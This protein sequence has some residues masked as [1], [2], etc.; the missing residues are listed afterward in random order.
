MKTVATRCSRASTLSMRILSILALGLLG[1]EMAGASSPAMCD[2]TY[3][4]GF[5]TPDESGLIVRA[6][7]ETVVTSDA[8]PPF[9][10]ADWQPPGSRPTIRGQVVI[11]V[12]VLSSDSAAVR[13]ALGAA[14]RAV[15]VPWAHD[16]GC[17]PIPWTSKPTWIKPG[18]GGFV[19]ARL[20]P[21]EKWAGALPTFDVQDAW[22]EPYRTAR[23]RPLAGVVVEKRAVMTPDEYG[24]FYQALP[25]FADWQRDQRRSLDAIFA[26]ERAHPD[27]AK[28]EPAATELIVRRRSLE[29]R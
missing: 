11:V 24:S 15:L 27:L 1:G 25:T 12:R 22:R 9:V 26:W 28:K 18:T 13:Q 7:D 29:A 14:K 17:E 16:S 2:Q 4:R 10:Y 8:L 21:R 5:R 20:R 6:L 23:A 19:A 3:F